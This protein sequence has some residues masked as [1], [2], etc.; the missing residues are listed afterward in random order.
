MAA[1]R[2]VFRQ[3]GYD[4]ATL[5]MLAEATGL[6]KPS[7][8]HHFPGGKEDMAKAAL[9]MVECGLDETFLAPLAA[10]GPAAERL[11]RMFVALDAYYESGRMGCLLA[12]LALQRGEHGLSGRIA[13]MFQKWIASLAALCRDARITDGEQR[14]ETAIALIQGGLVLAAGLNS[15]EPFHRA[16]AQA[17]KVMLASSQRRCR[18]P[19]SKNATQKPKTQTNHRGR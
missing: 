2:D 15:P 1:I 13:D 5:T 17:R 18:T 16:L 14:A 3:R 4:G 10:D 7:L 6:G 9:D 11:D 8:Y 12:I 19:P